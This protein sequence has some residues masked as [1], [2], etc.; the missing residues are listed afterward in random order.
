MHAWS[1]IVAS[2]ARAVTIWIE[3]SHVVF[4]DQVKCGEGR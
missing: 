2:E 1:K 3:G 4:I